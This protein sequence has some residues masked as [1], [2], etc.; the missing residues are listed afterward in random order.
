MLPLLGHLPCGQLTSIN[1]FFDLIL[2]LKRL[3]QIYLNEPS[4]AHGTYPRK[5]NFDVI[6]KFFSSDVRDPFRHFA[7]AEIINLLIR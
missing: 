3:K 2:K 6:V 1:R 7:F 4:E 5:P